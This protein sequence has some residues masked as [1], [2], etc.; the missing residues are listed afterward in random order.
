MNTYVRTTIYK[1]NILTWTEFIRNFIRPK[2]NE[3]WLQ[4]SYSLININLIVNPQVGQKKK[5]DDQNQKEVFIYFEPP[6]SKVLEAVQLP[7]HQITESSSSFQIMEKDLVPLVDVSKKSVFQADTE[8]TFLEKHLEQI[9]NFINNAYVEPQSILEQFTQY[10]FL[11]ER[12]TK[13]VF[14]N[15][16]G[17]SKEKIHINNLSREIIEQE[18]QEYVTARDE[19]Q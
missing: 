18:I 1:G 13:Q 12:N 6:I 10:Q 11:Y 7:L 14:K 4:N 15:L 9:K 8:S 19:I 17:E 5:K 3:E 16:F 2:E